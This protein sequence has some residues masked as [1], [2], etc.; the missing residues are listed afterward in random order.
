MTTQRPSMTTSMTRRL[1]GALGALGLL[2]PAS[3]LA[4]NFV[5]ENLNDDGPGSLRQ[6]I[7]AA[8]GN[9][10]ADMITFNE[11]LADGKIDL[12]SAQ[13]TIETDP[14]NLTIDGEVDGDGR[15]DITVDAKGRPRV[16]AIQDSAEVTLPEVVITGA[17][18]T[19]ANGGGIFNK[20]TLTVEGSTIRGNSAGFVSGVTVVT[21]SAVMDR[22]HLTCR[23]ASHCGIS[24]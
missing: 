1:G 23:D 24:A 8:N 3:A 12:S 15:P 20:G 2:V 21:E 19:L 4:E 17:S 7:E 9:G 18:G 22:L 5:L 13:L 6:A 16:F 14:A 11:T 10:E